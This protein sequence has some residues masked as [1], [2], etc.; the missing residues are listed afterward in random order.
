MPA[1]N[2]IDDFSERFLALQQEAKSYGLVSLVSIMDSDLLSGNE[3]AWYSY[4]GGRI[5]G[6]GLAECAKRYMMDQEVDA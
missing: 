3:G 1:P 2:T 5:A 6:I 4:L